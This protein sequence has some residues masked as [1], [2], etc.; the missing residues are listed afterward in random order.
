MPVFN[1]YNCFISCIQQCLWKLGLMLKKKKTYLDPVA[2][3]VWLDTT[4]DLSGSKGSSGLKWIMIETYIY[5]PSLLT[6]LLKQS[7][8]IQNRGGWLHLQSNRRKNTLRKYFDMG[9]LT[10]NTRAHKP[11]KTFP[12]LVAFVKLPASFAIVSLTLC[13]FTQAAY[14]VCACQPVGFSPQKHVLWLD[15]TFLKMKRD[16]SPPKGCIYPIQNVTDNS[17]AFSEVDHLNNYL[18]AHKEDFLFVC[19]C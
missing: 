11:V 18:S 10:K 12:F 17:Q 14:H 9:P 2:G 8:N 1:Q 3:T 5:I 16:F 19:F 7:L 4:L 6:W 13:T 15:G